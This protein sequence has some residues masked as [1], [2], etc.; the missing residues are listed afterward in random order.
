MTITTAT[1]NTS[2]TLPVNSMHCISLVGNFHLL[3]YN[4]IVPKYLK[5]LGQA[6]Q[7]LKKPA[8]NADILAA[9][10]TKISRLQHE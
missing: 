4:F 8:P 3:T 7:F 6:S 10:V 5:T 1:F 2:S 9:T